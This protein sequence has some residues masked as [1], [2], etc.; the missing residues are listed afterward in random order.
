[1]EKYKFFEHTADVKFRAYGKT[2][3][4]A[5]KN[6][7]LA[8]TK[9]MTDEKIKPKEEKTITK[10]ASKKESLLYDMVDELLFLID[11]EAFITAE[12]KELK[13]TEEDNQFK[14]TA[15]LSGDIA[16]NYEINTHIKAPT[17]T[18][19]EIKEEPELVT[20]QMVHDI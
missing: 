2:L 6:V 3:E 18:E 8:T 5:F 7:I 17:Y 4:E 11:T 19:M 13:I 10:T 14:L 12:V 9:I 15:T 1:M 20:I 16:D